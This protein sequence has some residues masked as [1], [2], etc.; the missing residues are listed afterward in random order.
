VLARCR[1][2]HFFDLPFHI[3]PNGVAARFVPYRTIEYNSKMTGRNFS[4]ETLLWDGF[5]YVF[6]VALS[7]RLRSRPVLLPFEKGHGD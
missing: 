5:G 7:L 4:F 3:G 2:R 1:A 6:G